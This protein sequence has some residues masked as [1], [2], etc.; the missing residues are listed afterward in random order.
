MKEKKLCRWSLDIESVGKLHTYICNFFYHTV[1][2]EMI[3]TQNCTRRDL[4][5]ELSAGSFFFGD[6]NTLEIL[7]CSFVEHF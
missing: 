5:K 6:L 4:F 3:V 2:E 7:C 1:L